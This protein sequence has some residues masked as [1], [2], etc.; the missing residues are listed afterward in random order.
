MPCSVSVCA[1]KIEPVKGT[2]FDF[3]SPYLIGEQ[4]RVVPT[5]VNTMAQKYTYGCVLCNDSIY[6]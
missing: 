6:I 5:T 3:T 1:G 2:V 4:I